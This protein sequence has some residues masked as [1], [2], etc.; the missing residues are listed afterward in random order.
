MPMSF[1]MAFCAARV[2]VRNQYYR[3]IATSRPGFDLAQRSGQAKAGATHGFKL[4]PAWP[5]FY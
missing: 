3:A 2:K 1:K 5:G 4:A